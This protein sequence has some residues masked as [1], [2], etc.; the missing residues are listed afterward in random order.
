MTEFELLA[1][2]IYRPEQLLVDYSPNPA[3]RMSLTQQQSESIESR[4]QQRLALAHAQGRRLY[5]GPLFR[6]VAVE[7]RSDGMLHL[8]LGDV[9]Y[10]E[11][12]ATRDDEVERNRPQFERA[13]PLSVCGAVETSDGYILLEQRPMTGVHAGRYHTPGGFID[14]EMDM[15]NGHIDLFGAMRRELREETGIQEDDI[16]EQYCLGVA[17]DLLLP[18]PELAFVL[19]L[20][21]P[22]D[23]VLRRKP[24]DNEIEHLLTLRATPEDVRDFLVSNRGRISPTG[25]PT[26]LLYGGYTFGE[27][28]YD[29]AMRRCIAKA[30]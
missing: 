21:I 28:W 27:S 1:R 26:L 18:H 5:D 13:N 16:R 7:P 2:H 23:E 15:H 9:G 24:E 10:K 12:T 29:D 20:N 19:R 30:E 6:L 4:W 11:Y 14:R 3:R 8:K 17:Y 25:E 22:L